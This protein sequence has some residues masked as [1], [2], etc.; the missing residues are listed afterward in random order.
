MHSSRD[1]VFLSESA[2]SSWCLKSHF[3]E[4]KI[5][6]NFLFYKM[7]FETSAG[8]RWFRQENDISRTVHAVFVLMGSKCR[9][10]SF[11]PAS[12]SVS[13]ARNASMSFSSLSVFSFSFSIRCSSRGF[14]PRDLMRGPSSSLFTLPL[15]TRSNRGEMHLGILLNDVQS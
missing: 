13:K 1:V 3:I 6:Y 15:P 11:V 9:K 12:S 2:K 8:F 7:R 14:E 5:I 10:F 4:K